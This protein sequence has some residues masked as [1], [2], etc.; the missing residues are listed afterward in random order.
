MDRR[1]E[2]YEK[3][4]ELFSE[5]GY[6]NTPIS[7]VSKSLGLSK[8][9]IYHYFQ[10]KE[11]LLF[12][13]H[14][15]FIKKNLIPILEKAEKISDPVE[16]ITYFVENNTRSLASD[17]SGRLLIREAPRLSPKNYE[18]IKDMWRRVFELL[19]GAV[20]EL[21][22]QGK[23]KKINHTFAAFAALGMMGWVI[24]WFDNARADSIEECA[25]NFTEIILRGMLKGE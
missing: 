24:Y 25:G 9:G 2:I 16:R 1:S 5:R 4:M 17:K 8:A 18:V 14:E 19:R 13:T 10:S 20:E 3:T 6:D 7:L 15:Y 21:D 23:T 22:R 12:R 11:E